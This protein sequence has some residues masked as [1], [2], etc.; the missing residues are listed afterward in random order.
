MFN[1]IWKSI[2]GIKTCNTST[3]SVSVI[4][5]YT[6]TINLT[7][8]FVKKISSF[9]SVIPKIAGFLWLL[10]PLS[11]SILDKIPFT[12]KWQKW[13]LRVL[14]GSC[15]SGNCGFGHIYWRNP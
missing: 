5:S 1:R 7:S 2:V 12:F 14:I 6:A 11:L 4:P 10:I 3:I 13:K 8:A 9:D 15:G